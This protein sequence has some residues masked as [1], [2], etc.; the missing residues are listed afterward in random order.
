MKGCETN[1][2]AMLATA[3]GLLLIGAEEREVLARIDQRTARELSVLSRVLEKR[4][5]DTRQILARLLSAEE[6]PTEGC[7][8]GPCAGGMEA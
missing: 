2:T 7:I 4:L 3:F 1:Q 8:C 6:A 5:V